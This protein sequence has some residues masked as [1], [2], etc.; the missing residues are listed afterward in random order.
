MVILILI[1]QKVHVFKVIFLISVFLRQK[2]LK[3]N[4][5]M[6]ILQKGTFLRRF[7]FRSL[8][9]LFGLVDPHPDTV[10]PNGP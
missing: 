6:I 7:G 10:K 2:K 4:I 8:P 5:D 9:V 3:F 1:S